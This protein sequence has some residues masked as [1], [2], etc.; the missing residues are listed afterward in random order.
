[1]KRVL[2][3][4]YVSKFTCISSDCDDTC[5]CGWRVAIDKESYEKYQ[6]L[7][8]TG[9]NNLFEGKITR[10]G[11][12]QVEGNY[13]EV[14]LT[15]NICP[16]LTDEKLC[17]IQ[18]LYGEN[19]LS[20]TCGIFPR[21][22]E[23]VNGQLELS[24]NLSCPHAARLALLDSLPM[25]FSVVSIKADPRIAKI[26]SVNLSD[27]EYPNSIYPYF[28]E[29]RTFVLALLQNRKYCFEYRLIILGRF[30]NDLNLMHEFSKDDVLQ[31]ICEY[32]HLIDSFGFNKFI[33]SIPDQPAAMLKMLMSLLEYRLKTGVT[34]KGFIECV[35]Q[36]KHGLHYTDDIQDETLASE[37]REIQLNYYDSFM[38]QYEYI[39]ENYF[40]NYV[41]KELFP[42]GQ[43]TSIHDK[44]IFTVQKTVFTEYILMVLHYTMTKNLLIGMAGYY[45]NQFGTQQ[46]VKLIQ[47]YD[48]NINHDIPYLQR[49]LQF[50]SDNNMINVACAA[51]LIK[52]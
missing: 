19:Y 13:A 31:L 18:K 37:Y 20:V 46:V 8:Y 32:T 25:Q 23:L 5:C 10:D 11:I 43:Q 40:V 47:S 33:N 39:F 51:M 9:K 6:S 2:Q 38:K 49:L 28:Q 17:D 52:N 14:V 36:F 48:K 24:L 35:D 26:P 45:K 50:F 29:V 27:I 7:M 21:N 22:Y 16:F 12:M 34:G 3:P 42:F 1:M 30:C 15:K 4:D 44:S 41:F